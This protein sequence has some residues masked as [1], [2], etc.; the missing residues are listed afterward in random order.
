M[1]RMT[2]YD[3][4]LEGFQLEDIFENNGG[5]LTPEL[6]ERLDNLLKQ[7]P[8][9]I[10]SATM[11]TREMEATAE[12]CRSEAKRLTDRAISLEKQAQKLKDRIVVALDAAFNGKVKTALFTVYSQKAADTL[13]VDIS[14]EYTAEQIHQDH[15]ELIKTEYSL[16]KGATRR[17]WE[18][19]AE[20]YKAAKSI[21]ANPEADDQ[22]R[23]W[24]T[25]VVKV[26]PD[27]LVIEE[28]QGKRYLRI[29]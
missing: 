1:T 12:I 27:C 25:E 17:L 14:E 8:A 28:K 6:E 29:R 2:L 19:N 10:E 11:V 3:I 21:L 24:A 16:D 18:Q 22:L 26:I 13:A 20:S 5:E 23:A 4:T 9:K 15:P 7:G